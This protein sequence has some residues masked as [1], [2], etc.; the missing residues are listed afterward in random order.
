MAAPAILNTG[1]LLRRAAA[2]RLRDM[3]PRL[4]AVILLLAIG[5]QSSVVAFAGPSPVSHCEMNGTSHS[6][7]SQDPCCPKTPHL[8][9]CCLAACAAAM[10]GPVAMPPLLHRHGLVTLLPQFLSTRFSSRGDSPLIRPP[11]L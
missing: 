11:I 7:S 6:D 10:P 2:V 1:D 4:I 9:G 3:K 8:M 5:L